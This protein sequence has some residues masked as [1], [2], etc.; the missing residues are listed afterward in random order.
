[1]SLQG[2]REWMSTEGVDAAYVTNPISIGYLTGFFGHPVE[3]LMALVVRDGA[4]DLIV[5]GLDLDA[6]RAAATGVDVHGWRDGEDPYRLVRDA[7]GAVAARLAV[8]KGHLSLAGFERLTETVTAE[9]VVD[10]TGPLRT[11][12]RRKTP[13]E[14]AKLAEAA[15]ITDQVTD[16]VFTQLHTGQSEAEVSLFIAHAFAEAG[17]E[18][19]FP[20][21][22]QF[23][24]NA[25]MGH[26]QAGTRR[27]SRGEVVVLD[28]GAR[29]QGYCADTTRVAVAGE[30]DDTQREVHRVVLAAHDAA[31]AAVRPGVTA[32]AVD[33]AAR[34]VIRDAG[35]GERFVHRVGHGLGLEDHEDPS[36]DPGSQAVLEAGMAITIEPGI[37]IPGWGGVRIEDDLIVE[38][39][40]A[41]VL[42]S[43]TRDLLV[44]S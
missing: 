44:V 41:R 21:L 12:R 3:R 25:A 39:H 30:P 15:R 1:M 22:A 32:G 28:F 17:A 16:A 10:A 26:H 20:T 40:G 5:P 2:M 31:V 11:L 6:A 42:T 34:A 9:V 18:H 35:Y 29:W 24:P 14:V 4:A 19:S 23:G 7:A 27:L 33:E 43:A 8:E 13:E 37:Y 38:E 36:L